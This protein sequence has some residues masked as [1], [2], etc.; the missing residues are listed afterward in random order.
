M[1]STPAALDAAERSPK[2]HHPWAWQSAAMNQRPARL[3]SQ[4]K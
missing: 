2:R 3:G 4:L 1:P